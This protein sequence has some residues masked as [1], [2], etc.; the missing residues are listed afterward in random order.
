MIG[1]SLIEKAR[2]VL[3]GHHGFRYNFLANSK[4]LDELTTSYLK[5][6]D[7][8]LAI[9]HGPPK[10]GIT[11]VLET[12]AASQEFEPIWPRCEEFFSRTSIIDHVMDAVGIRFDHE[13]TVSI[14][15]GLVEFAALSGRRIIIFDG[16]EDYLALKNNVSNILSGL[17][18]L[19]SSSAKFFVVVTTQNIKLLQKCRSFKSEKMHEVELILGNTARDSEDFMNCFWGWSNK[20][21]ALNVGL[22]CDLKKLAMS[23]PNSTSLASLLTRLELLYAA[24]LMADAG[25]MSI[26]SFSDLEILEWEVLNALYS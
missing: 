10:C 11:T 17:D 20:L 9:L 25:D 1:L 19:I 2:T 12:F 13:F 22:S 6:P 24:A 23:S 26:Y 14:P 7:G 3:E 21:L 8:G 15:A 16:L 18:Q 4:A 5:S